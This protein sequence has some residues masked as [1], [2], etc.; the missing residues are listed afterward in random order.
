M[1]EVGKGS[2]NKGLCN[3]SG[4]LCTKFR[5]MNGRKPRLREFTFARC[6]VGRLRERLH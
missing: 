5:Q 4:D 6:A 2:I 1:K 3:P